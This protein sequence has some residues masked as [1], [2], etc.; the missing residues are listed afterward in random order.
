MML[1]EYKLLRIARSMHRRS[2]RKLDRARRLYAVLTWQTVQRAANPALA[3]WRAS[4]AAKRAGLYAATTFDQDICLS[5]CLKWF[6]CE[7]GKLRRQDHD[8]W[9]KFVEQFRLVPR[10]TRSQVAKWE[11]DERRVPAIQA[12]A[13]AGPDCSWEDWG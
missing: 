4:I 9:H 6:A 8:S 1:T 13:F 3:C 11:R 10:P 2:R 12:F 7:T 5:L